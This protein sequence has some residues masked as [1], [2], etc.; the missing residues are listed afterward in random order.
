MSK[1]YENFLKALDTE[2]E[3]SSPEHREQV[4]KLFFSV[5]GCTFPKNSLSQ[6]IE[7]YKHI[8][9]EFPRDVRYE[10]AKISGRAL[11]HI[12]KGVKS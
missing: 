12:A 6:F 4:K 9:Y 2:I 3:K 10:A 5:W 11:S 1:L 8:R 7:N